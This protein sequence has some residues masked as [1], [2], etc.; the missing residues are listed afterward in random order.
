[1]ERTRPLRHV[2]RRAGRTCHR[3]G[4]TIRSHAQGESARIAYWCPG[5]QGGREP[6]PA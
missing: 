4:K 5:C 1:M 3:C 2:H 6:G